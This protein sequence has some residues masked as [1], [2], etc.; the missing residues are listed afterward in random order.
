VLTR[1]LAREARAEAHAA[2]KERADIRSMVSSWKAAARDR[3]SRR[4]RLR[5]ARL[6]LRGK[7]DLAQAEADVR[8][9]MEVY[10]AHEQ[11]PTAY[12]A[13]AIL[14]MKYLEYE[15]RRMLARLPRFRVD[16]LREIAVSLRQQGLRAM[17]E[18]RGDA[19]CGQCTRQ[20]QPSLKGGDCCSGMV[21][22]GWDELDAT[23]RVLLGERAPVLRVFAGDWSR[24]GFLGDHGCVLPAGTRPM[25]CTSY[26]CKSYQEDLRRDARWEALSAVL[27]ELNTE[28]R[29]LGFRVNLNKRFV[30]GTVSRSHE[31]HPLDFVWERLRDRG[32]ERTARG[33]ADGLDGAKSRLSIVPS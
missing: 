2:I 11:W 27:T 5:R 10:E 30:H 15:A 4:E 13:Q 24:C 12:R 17:E 31:S 8:E 25:V 18:T 3:D 22:L 14:Q 6:Y 28:R 26:Y 29:A 19:Q 7:W 33:R 9:A 23:F 32:A 16:Q 1:A 20:L 21:F